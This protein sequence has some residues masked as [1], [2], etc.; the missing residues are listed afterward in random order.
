MTEI[1]NTG[2]VC[3]RFG[4]SV[5]GIYLKFGICLLAGRRGYW[6]L[7]YGAAMTTRI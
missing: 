6:N 3:E 2:Q 4:H 7:H 1:P 5:I